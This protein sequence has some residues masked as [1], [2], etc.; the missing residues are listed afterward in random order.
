LKRIPA[1]KFEAVN[2]SSCMVQRSSG[3][4]ACPGA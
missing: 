1:S 3:K 4:A 2:T